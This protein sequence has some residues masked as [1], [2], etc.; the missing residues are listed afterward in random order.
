MLD[1]IAATAVAIVAGAQSGAALR[2]GLGML[3]LQFAIGSANDLADS[4]A[5]AVAKPWKPI[6]AGLM[7]RRAA[8]V[9]C[10]TASALG[11]SLA[12]TVSAGALVVA[13]V[14]LADGLIYDLRLKATP[15]A[16]LPFAVGVGL[17]PLY[18]WLGARNSVGP[19][20]VGIV[21]ISVVAGA[22]LALANAY[23]DLDRDRRS[24]V[25]SIAVFLG[26]RW[27]VTLNASLLLIVQMVAGATTIAASGSPQLIV[28]EVVGCGLGWLGL[29]LAAVGRD[30]L[31]PLVWEVQAI[32]LVVLGTAWLAAL[33]AAGALRG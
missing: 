13:I 12:A 27:T 28:V 17:L 8:V 7:P 22:T 9:L 33:D 24:G 2:L 21:A 1:A 26:S 30:R 5:D 6:P 29:C 16:W 32:G 15:L 11:L 3:L 23:A 4:V 31:R 19:A 18:A 14:G 10:V 25:R 20:F